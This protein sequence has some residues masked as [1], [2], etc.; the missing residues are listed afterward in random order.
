MQPGAMRQTGLVCS[1]ILDT[2]SDCTLIP[3]PL[4]QR[5][6]ARIVARA[7]QIPVGGVIAV[8]IPYVVGMA[9]DQYHLPALRVFGCS[10]SDIGDML[11]IGRDLMNRYRIEFDGPKLEFKIS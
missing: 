2:G 8:A 3:I 1:A 9:F 6:N 10:E 7:I 11:L 4:L 5:V